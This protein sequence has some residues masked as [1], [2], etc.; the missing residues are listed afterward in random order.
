MFSTRDYLLDLTLPLCC[1][2]VSILTAR[3]LIAGEFPN[4][5]SFDVILVVD[6]TYPNGYATLQRKAQT[7]LS[8]GANS[9]LHFCACLG[10]G[11][12][13]HPE[14]ARKVTLITERDVEFQAIFTSF[15][16]GELDES[17]HV[18]R[19]SIQEERTQKVC[20]QIEMNFGSKG[21]KIGVYNGECSMSTD[22]GKKGVE[23]A[24]VRAHQIRERTAY[25]NVVLQDAKVSH[26]D[27]STRV[28]VRTTR[29]T[30][31]GPSAFLNVFCMFVQNMSSAS[32]QGTFSSRLHDRFLT[33][34]FLGHEVVNVL[35]IDAPGEHQNVSAEDRRAGQKKWTGG[36][37]VQRACVHL[38]HQNNIKYCGEF[39]VTRTSSKKQMQM[40]VPYL[41]VLSDFEASL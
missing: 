21:Q 12:H 26:Y 5:T 29:A 22:H 16:R 30:V 37:N 9:S 15:K 17:E 23:E 3:K 6:S 31:A 2:A 7:L 39:S 33:F 34:G 13:G 20:Y 18:D 35:L 19:R 36:A 41:L 11:G 8:S 28:H 10:A 38:L 24:I 40:V 14:N 27:A 32:K 25:R 4:D 1:F